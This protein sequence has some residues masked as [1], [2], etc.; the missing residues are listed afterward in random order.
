MRVEDSGGEILYP[1]C[2]VG[3][4]LFLSKVMTE[5]FFRNPNKS[6]ET[7]VSMVIHSYTSY[8]KNFVKL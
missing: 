4:G 8:F 2:K 3:V 5:M 7:D 1:Y 6:D